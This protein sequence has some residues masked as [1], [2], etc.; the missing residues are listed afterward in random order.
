MEVGW[1]WIT[2][3]IL[4]FS[5][6]LSWVWDTFLWS[7]HPWMS[8]NTPI[9]RLSGVASTFPLSFSFDRTS[10]KWGMDYVS[11]TTSLFGTL[12][13]HS[14][15]LLCPF[16]TP[17]PHQTYH[18][19]P[20][21]HRPQYHLLQRPPGGADKDNRGPSDTVWG[22]LFSQVSNIQ[23]L[24]SFIPHAY[25]MVAHRLWRGSCDQWSSSHVSMCCGSSPTHTRRSPLSHFLTVS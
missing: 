11:D 16:P 22:R 25:S 10:M 17:T 19:V 24:T 13:A 21:V 15:F 23:H 18:A 5:V 6:L 4:W 7:P 2:I 3:Y 14:T 1:L 20:D 8:H 9:L 12:V